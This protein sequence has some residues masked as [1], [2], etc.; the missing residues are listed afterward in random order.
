M[1]SHERPTND[2]ITRVLYIDRYTVSLLALTVEI[3][4][5]IPIQCHIFLLSTKIEPDNR[6]RSKIVVWAIWELLLRV[7]ETQVALPAEVHASLT[8]LDRVNRA[9]PLE[10]QLNRIVIR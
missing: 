2:Q 7:M 4:T 5:W 10:V 3:L 9:E 8:M 1:L 6:E